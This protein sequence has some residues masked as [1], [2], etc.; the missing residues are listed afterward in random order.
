MNNLTRFLQLSYR[1]M[2]AW[3]LS[4]PLHRSSSLDFGIRNWSDWRLKKRR[5]GGRCQPYAA[6]I[7]NRFDLA[8]TFLDLAKVG[9][10]LLFF[11]ITR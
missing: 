5:L 6:L 10:S 11:R 9:A 1:C 7:R 3:T 2:N 8:I 4:I